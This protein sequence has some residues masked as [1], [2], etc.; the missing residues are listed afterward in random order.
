MV[1]GGRNCVG[2]MKQDH[3]GVD[4]EPKVAKAKVT[5]AKS[6][7]GAFTN[8]RGAKSIMFIFF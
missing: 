8:N 2:S 3:N 4:F 5:S 7:E 6:G 1:E